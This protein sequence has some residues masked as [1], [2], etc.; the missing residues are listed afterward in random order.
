MIQGLV[1]KIT[2][3][4]KGLPYEEIVKILKV[5][6]LTVKQIRWNIIKVY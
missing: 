2:T 5:L 6:S 1:M 4:T 3:D